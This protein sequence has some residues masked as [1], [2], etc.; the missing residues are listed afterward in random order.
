MH[1]LEFTYYPNPLL[2][3]KAKPVENNPVPEILQVMEQ[4]KQ[5]CSHREGIGLAAQQVGLILPILIYSVPKNEG[6]NT[7]IGVVNPHVVEEGKIT[8]IREEGCLSFP[9]LYFQ[10]ERPRRIVAEGWFDDTRQFERRELFDM[11]ARVFSHECD[12]IN[13]ILYIDRIDDEARRAIK[14]ELQ[15][16]AGMSHSTEKTT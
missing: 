14:P 12:H 7:L 2:R 16:I 8:A 10:I 15:R 11:P 1:K 13:G 4:M 6:G 5:I 3:Q 9:G